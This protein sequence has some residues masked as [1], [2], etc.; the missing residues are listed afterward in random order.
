MNELNILVSI[1]LFFIGLFCVLKPI[2]VINIF[3]NFLGKD[4]PKSFVSFLLS[5]NNIFWFRISGGFVI[6]FSI[7]YMISFLKKLHFNFLV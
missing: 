7:L 2:K 4:A 5:K 1:F 6:L 3:I